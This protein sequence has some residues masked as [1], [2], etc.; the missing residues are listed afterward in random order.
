MIT[1]K[2]PQSEFFGTK[3]EGGGFPDWLSQDRDAF[4][5]TLQCGNAIARGI[6]SVLEEQ[7]QLPPVSFTRLHRLHDDSGD[8]VRVLRYPGAPGEPKDDPDESPPHKDA[9]SVALLFTWLGGLQI[10]D[11]SAKVQGLA[12]NPEDWRRV[13]PEPGYAIV[14][15]RRR[16]GDLHQQDSQVG[17]PPFC[18]SSRSA[19]RSRQ[20][21]RSCGDEA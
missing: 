14:K 9:M 13:R 15:P 7:L 2:V 18:Q 1:L 19:A 3:V 8:F 4:K 6:L 17:H 5:T 21:E 16:D 10:P 12:V 11:P 20:G